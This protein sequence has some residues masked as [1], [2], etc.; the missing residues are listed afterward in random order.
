MARKLTPQSHQ[1]SILRKGQCQAGTHSINLSFDSVAG[2]GS[3]GPTFRCHGTQPCCLDGKQSRCN[4]G[5]SVFKLKTVQR[6]MAGFCNQLSTKYC[7][8]LWPCFKP[9]QKMRQ[10][11]SPALNDLYGQTY[12]AR[13]LRPL[14]RR[15]AMTERPPR[16]FMR[17]RKPCV[18]AR[19]TF[20]GWYVRFMMCPAACVKVRYLIL[21]NQSEID[22]QLSPWYLTKRLA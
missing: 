13:R 2:H 20:D 7:L 3:F 17:V 22:C 21:A 10:L 19:L 8:K 16:V 5:G 9:L 11:F 18:R 14:A 1:K 15:A 12:T 6:K 4:C